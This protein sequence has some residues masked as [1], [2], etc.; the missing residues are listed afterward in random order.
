[1]NL[2]GNGG[3][4]EV[5]MLVSVA[6]ALLAAFVT[7]I[8]FPETLDKS[9]RPKTSDIDQ[10]CAAQ[11]EVPPESNE[12]HRQRNSRE[13]ARGRVRKAWHDVK[14][15]VSGTGFANILLLSVSILCATV[16]I[17]ATDWYGLVQ[18]PVI[19]FG[20]TFPQ[21]RTLPNFSAPSTDPVQGLLCCILPGL[22]HA[23]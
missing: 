8:F 18:Y 21:V 13:V 6:T 17:K 9:K 10:A 23:A 7:I 22:V 5:A 3:T 4:P 20:W 14:I 19:K 16:G 12:G 15:G 1:M 11:E 2:D